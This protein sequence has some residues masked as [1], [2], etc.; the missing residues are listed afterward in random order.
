MRIL[1]TGASGLLGL[2]LSLAALACHEVIGVDRSR[3]AGV[4]FE[5][6]NLDLLETGVVDGMLERVRPDWLI[7]CAALA[8]WMP[9]R[10]I[11]PVACD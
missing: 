1:I 11:L 10:Q 5:L 9:A 2:N 4:P 8:M 3:L 7:H 6:L